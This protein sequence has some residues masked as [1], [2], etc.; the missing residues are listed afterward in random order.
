MYS[1]VHCIGV[2]TYIYIGLYPCIYVCMH[3]CTYTCMYL[4]L[5]AYITSYVTNIRHRSH[6][7]TR[8]MSV[9]VIDE[10]RQW[11][12]LEARVNGRHGAEV[13]KEGVRSV[14]PRRGTR[15]VMVMVAVEVT[16]ERQVRQVAMGRLQR[17]HRM[18]KLSDLVLDEVGAGCKTWIRSVNPGCG[19][20]GSRGAEGVRI[21]REVAPRTLW[22]DRHGRRGFGRPVVPTVQQP[23]RVRLA[24]LGGRAPASPADESSRTDALVEV[25]VTGKQAV[26]RRH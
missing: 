12:G 20:R 9:Y 6:A 22:H 26:S 10:R 21:G 11:I 18:S 19:P 13:R 7:L 14:E 3:V 4:S 24:M 17:V 1:F 2:C 16:V 23:T 8:I 5:Y 15:L 25:R